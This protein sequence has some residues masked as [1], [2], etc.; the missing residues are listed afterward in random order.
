MG[1]VSLM[2]VSES[3]SEAD[4]RWL[5]F[6]SVSKCEFR[7]ASHTGPIE[8][9]FPYEVERLRP[10]S[11]ACIATCPGSISAN[12]QSWHQVMGL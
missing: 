9:H 7:C 10:C 2:R 11:R 6:T 5:M 1:Q 3:G 4:D 8:P 12:D